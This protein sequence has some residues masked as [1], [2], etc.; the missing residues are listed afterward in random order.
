MKRHRGTQPKSNQRR[1]SRQS[2]KRRNRAPRSAQEFFA[3]SE[4]GQDRWT[5]ATNVITKMRNDGSSLPTAAREY[6]MT[7]RAVL[8]LAKSAL[9]KRPN[10]QFAARSIDHLL[11]ILVIPTTGGLREVAVGDSRQASQLGEYWAAVQKYLATGDS[12]SLRRI[13]RKTIIDS[14]GKRIRLVKD[15][16][17]L[18]RLGSAG[19]LSFESLYAKAA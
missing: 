12:S 16:A 2:T 14:N 5:R 13:R 1:Q 15:L 18:D 7:S 6:G 11:R 19:V 8:S 10:G 3:M 17:D 9:K 4:K